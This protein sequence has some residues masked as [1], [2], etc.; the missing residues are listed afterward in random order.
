MKSRAHFAQHH[1]SSTRPAAP[2]NPQ[3]KPHACSPSV[4]KRR[5]RFRSGSGSY[6]LSVLSN[7]SLP[8]TN[9]YRPNNIGS[10]IPVGHLGRKTGYEALRQLAQNDPILQRSFQKLLRVRYVLLGRAE[11]AQRYQPGHGLLLWIHGSADRPSPKSGNAKRYRGLFRVGTQH[12]RT[13]AS[14]YTHTHTQKEKKKRQW[15]CRRAS[16]A[17]SEA[18]SRGLLT[19][20]RDAVELQQGQLFLNQKISVTPFEYGRML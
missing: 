12:I 17:S 1:C 3:L 2:I 16:M 5:A 19:P 8:Y 11:D 13:S 18:P 14:S 20:V 10:I 9:T 6:R 15:G 7:P 4:Q